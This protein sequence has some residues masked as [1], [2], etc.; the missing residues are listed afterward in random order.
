MRP[1]HELSRPHGP[2]P[3]PRARPRP[4]AETAGL[5]ALQ[6]SAGNSAVGSL[7]GVQRKVGWTGAGAKSPN[8]DARDTKGTSVLRIPVEG[9]KEG[10]SPGRAI[11]LVP[12]AAAQPP[13][14]VEVLFHLHGWFIP[15]FGRGYHEHGGK[16]DD[17]ALY[18]I[19]QQLEASGR[20]MI[21]ILPQGP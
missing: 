3:R 1:E 6:R 16:V 7:L 14:T 2:E 15:G 13:T 4:T 18:R 12:H 9:I 20:T 17:E 21:G 11:V 10:V 19:E 8:R 5:L